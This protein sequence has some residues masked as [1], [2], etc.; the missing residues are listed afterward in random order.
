M[1]RELNIICETCDKPIG[2]GED[3][4]GDLWVAG[5][6]VDRFRAE[7][8]VWEAKHGAGPGGGVV[9]WMTLVNY[10]ERARWRAH[11]SA[12]DSTDLAAMYAIQASELRTWTQMAGWTA[13]LMGKTWLTD[14]DWQKIL[15]GLSDGTGTRVVPVATV[16]D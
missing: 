10:P 6:D 1:T 8:A 11:H 4:P 16:N 13:H 3:D 12:C 14:T 15:Q 9:G 2:G 5:A 7:V